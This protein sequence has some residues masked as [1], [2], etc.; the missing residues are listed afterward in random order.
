MHGRSAAQPTETFLVQRSLSK[1]KT[2]VFVGNVRFD[3]K[4]QLYHVQDFFENGQIQMDATYGSLNKQ[5]KE[6]YQC[7]YRAN[8]KVPRDSKIDYNKSL[9]TNRRPAPRLRLRRIRC[10]RPLPAAVGELIVRPKRKDRY[11]YVY[12]HRF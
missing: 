7:N 1:S 9:H 8:T 12:D 6:D 11:V 4:D 2:I 3:E 10:Q 5:I